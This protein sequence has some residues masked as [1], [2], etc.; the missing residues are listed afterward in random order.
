MTTDSFLLST[1]LSVPPEE[2]Y[3]AW[4]DADRHAAFTAATVE[5]RV[6]GRFT[7]WNGYIEGITE[8]LEPGQLIVQSWRTSEFPPDAPDSRLELRLSDAEGSTRLVLRHTNIPAGQGTRY[9]SGWQEHYF[10]P[11]AVYF[12]A[13]PA[14]ARPK[15][16]TPKKQVATRATG[17]A[18]AAK[19]PPP[20]KK[21][22][23]RA[24]KKAAPGKKPPKKL[25]V[26]KK[27]GKRATKKAAPRKQ[28]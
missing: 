9:E 2:L 5:P 24:A 13:P 1:L 7:A 14:E 6:G 28:R 25:L 18:A 27:V 10:E 22:A 21:V 15:K 17:K 11:M 16:T 19:K 3:A 12:S 20:S 4:L 8:A 26:A 23:E